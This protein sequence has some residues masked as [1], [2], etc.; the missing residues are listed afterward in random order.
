MDSLAVTSVSSRRRI[1]RARSWLES[2]EPDEE[3]VIVGATVGAANELARQVASRNGAAF[4]WHRISLP[5]LVSI[6]AAPELNRRGVVSLTRIGTDAVT[7]R[8]IHRLR[9]D[10]RLGRYSS[11]S[12]TPGFP[13][14]IANVIVELRSAGVR[15]N[16]IEAVVP[17]FAP[18]VREYERELAE[19]GF[20][21]WPGTLELAA[22]AIAGSDRHRLVGLPVLMFDVPVRTEAEAHAALAKVRKGEVD[23]I[24][25]PRF[26]SLNIPGF[27]L[28]TAQKQGLPTMFHGFFFVERG[29]L[30]AYSAADSQLGRQAARLVDKILNGAKPAD[31]PVE[32]PTKFELVINVKTAKG[33]G[34]PIP[35]SVLLRADRLIE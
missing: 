21:D 27:I 17:D 6:V 4:G 20:I 19:G 32:Q 30:V 25:S 12:E 28:D 13:G 8:L 34:L 31:L 33:L 1:E 18:I 9:V 10:G 14:A 7:T 24:L 2:R 3:L 26:L 5:Q 29:G 35:R 11:V 23:G 22:S 15:S 16:E